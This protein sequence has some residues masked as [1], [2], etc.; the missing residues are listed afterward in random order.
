MSR[1]AK[2]FGSI[3]LTIIAI[4]SAA[5]AAGH[6]TKAGAPTVQPPL[7]R[8]H[9]I[10]GTPSPM[11]TPTSSA[12]TPQYPILPGAGVVVAEPS[13]AAQPPNSGYQQPNLGSNQML[14]PHNLFLST[15]RLSPQSTRPTLGHRVKNQT[16]NSGSP[17][18]TG[19]NHW[20]TYEEDAIPGIGK[21]MINV[22]TGNLLVQAD[23]MAVA[24][25]GIE[26]AFRR[27][28]NSFSTHDYAN[29]DGSVPNNYGDG[30][31]NTF[32]AHVS[33]NTAGFW[34]VYDID[35]ARYDYGSTYV[36]G[37][38]TCY[39]PPVG[40]FATLCSDGANGLYWTKKT[41]T[42]YY[43]F[44]TV[45]VTPVLVGRLHEIFGRHHNNHLLFQYYA[46]ATKPLTYQYLNKITVTTEANAVSTLFFG[47]VP[48]QGSTY[49]ELA[50]IFFPD[51][52]TRV[53]YAYASNNAGGASLAETD[54][55][56][57][58][59]TTNL[60]GNL[61]PQQ[62]TYTTRLDKV[63]SP[64]WVVSRG[65]TPGP[66]TSPTDG[67]QL[68]FVYNTGPFALASVTYTTNADPL[69]PAS[70]N[71]APNSVPAS[72]VQS[73]YS[74]APYLSRTVSV[75]YPSPT[76]E[77]CAS[78][79]AAAT[80]W[81]DS[82]GHHTAYCV[83]SSQRVVESH[84]YTGDSAP[85]PTY[86]TLKQ[87]WDSNSDLTSTKD[88]RGNQTD[89]A[90][91]SN[92][93][94]IAV[95]APAVGGIRATSLY[96][97]DSNNNVLAYCD[98]VWSN[99]NGKN[100]S[101]PASPQAC[102]QQ[103]GVMQL[104]W[105]PPTGGVDPFGELQTMTKPLGYSTTFA[106]ALGPQ[107]GNDYGLPTSATGSQI[108]QLAGPA[109]TPTQNFSYD[110]SGNLI[111]YSKATSGPT[112]TPAPSISPIP[113]P[114][115]ATW[116]LAY[117]QDS[118]V[119]Q[120]ADPDDG[121]TLSVNACGKASNSTTTVSY[122]YYYP[123]GQLQETETAA[124]HALDQTPPS[125]GVNF[126][127]GGVSYQYDADGNATMEVHNHGFAQGLT[128]KWYDGEDRLV[129]VL[130]P[131]EGRQFD[132]QGANDGSSAWST[133][134]I[135]DLTQGGTVSIG[136]TT[137]IAAHE[138]LFKTQ[139]NFGT[140]WSD[141]KGNAFDALD[142]T[143]AKYAYAPGVNGLKT[144]SSTYD[145]TSGT[146]GLLSTSVDPLSEVATL[147][148]DAMGRELQVVYSG[149]NGLTPGETYAYDEDGRT[150]SITSN[151]NPSQEQQYTY[152]ADGNKLTSVEPS[153][154]GS[155]A[156]LT[157]VYYSNGWRKSLAVSS[158]T[159]TQTSPP[160]FQYAYRGDGRLAWQKSNY[161]SANV[162]AKLYTAAGRLAG[163]FDPVGATA[164]GY[165]SYGQESSLHLAVPGASTTIGNYAYDAEGSL[166][167]KTFSGLNPTTNS[168]NLR[169]E[170]VHST[171]PGPGVGKF[172]AHSVHGYMQP[173]NNNQCS[174]TCPGDGLDAVVVDGFNAVALSDGPPCPLGD[175]GAP[176]TWAYDNAGRM[177]TE[178]L[179]FYLTQKYSGLGTETRTYDAL[180]RTEAQNSQPW[181]LTCGG[182]G[183]DSIN[184]Y[185]TRTYT[186]GPNGHP[187]EI[188][189][190]STANFGQQ[191]ADRRLHWDGDQ[192]L[193]TSGTGQLDD[194]KVD[195]TADFT[196]QD[197]NFTGLTMWDRDLDGAAFS[198]HNTNG[199][200]G[201]TAHSPYGLDHCA[202]HNT[203][204]FPASFGW[205][206]SGSNQEV[207]NAGL[208]IEPRTD[209]IFDGIN[210]IQGVRTYDDAASTWTSPDAYAGEVDD[211]MSQ[212][213]YMW[214]R[215]D[216]VL[217]SD[218]SGYCFEFL[219]PNCHN[220]PPPKTDA[221]FKS[222]LAHNVISEL[223][224]IV[225]LALGPEDAPVARLGAAEASDAAESGLSKTVD[226]FLQGTTDHIRLENQTDRYHN[227]TEAE[228]KAGGVSAVEKEITK[229]GQTQ[230]ELFVSGT[231]DGVKG[232]FEIIK[233]AS[234]E[235]FHWFFR[236][237]R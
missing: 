125:P 21:Y 34:S 118:R 147:T 31:T 81:S 219:V 79:A 90:F 65:P 117:D 104:T 99:T 101:P 11:P 57:N 114:T 83:D 149:D 86:L 234:G 52:V 59:S 77:N 123:N 108:N 154:L 144:W 194:L 25:K 105:G 9:L 165:D 200:A 20:W 41:G 156:T 201:I 197:A 3:S 218:P 189:S 96:L 231:L 198:M 73:G 13:M 110:A 55:P 209:G 119:T 58:G 217:Y 80:D 7:I 50:A 159:L 116:A 45:G 174:G 14:R 75:N 229:N 185:D 207:A 1:F 186:W 134:Y 40:Q 164:Y 155:A 162:F 49:R 124:Q 28:Y 205:V 188:V 130:L 38:Q 169:G 85:G 141:V 113:A 177:T 199:E 36:S 211:P 44:A 216:P 56:S 16:V 213:S 225:A 132:D 70:S 192:L 89:Y 53:N 121:S 5:L 87:G 160:L 91:D 115:T 27:T 43:F 131:Y 222:R 17:S 151:T 42:V 82:Y 145:A 102:P 29:S 182:Y 170:I 54:E 74:P 180:N 4:G 191:T 187:E 235:V 212:K 143:T 152:D 214:N 120:I 10:V 127:P 37:G 64:R 224:F 161:L 122:K 237:S 107:G 204:G 62:Y 226:D 178:Q 48:I 106:Y 100:W 137:G 220:P 202:A 181:P 22:G 183:S 111:C 150:L 146:L 210:T 23:D 51:N 2:R 98:P 203:T 18:G 138:N 136:S 233:N 176:Q 12:G 112:P 223:I 163:Q 76:S 94:T 15:A 78:G 35:G 24:N 139:E 167:Q 84:E 227:F 184:V 133:R 8:Q 95:A 236:P 196:P 158:Q 6:Q 63:S 206:F 71:G 47:D 168:Y 103:S 175:C 193:F 30:W 173:I 172:A 46:D 153:S 69:I 208:I 166:T 179:R 97:Y 228:V 140:A 72:Q 215:N 232:T 26:L 66:T 148:Y 67:T 39:T 33:P 190:T 32:D 195:T 61:V 129:E 60:T 221:E 126:P 157:N 19:I 142:R 135:Y 92:G 128:Q 93:N 171:W 109:V 230:F 68:E 88:A